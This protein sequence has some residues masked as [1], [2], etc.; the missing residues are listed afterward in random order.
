MDVGTLFVVTIVPDTTKRVTVAPDPVRIATVAWQ[1]P[2]K[3][4][5]EGLQCPGR[6]ETLSAYLFFARAQGLQTLGATATK[7]LNL[8]LTVALQRAGG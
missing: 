2:K 5:A 3:D 1:I 6:R 8:T 7:T 4:Q